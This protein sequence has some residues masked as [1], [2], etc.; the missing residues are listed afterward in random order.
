MAVKDPSQVRQAIADFELFLGGKRAP[1]LIGHSLAT[2]LRMEIPQLANIIINWSSQVKDQYLIDVILGARNKVFDIFFYRV[3]KFEAIYSFFPVFEQNLIEFCPSDVQAHLAAIFQ[4]FPWQ[5]IRPIGTFREQ[6]KFVIE[7][8]PETKVQSEAF[9]DTIYKNAT[10]AVMSIDKKFTFNDEQTGEKIAGFQNKVQGIFRDFVDQVKDK[11]QKKEIVLANES[12][13]Y[14]DYQKK[15]SFKIEQYLTQ[16]LDLGIALFNDDFL[17]QSVQIFGIIQELRLEYKLNLDDVKKFQDKAEFFS[18]QK[19]ED[20]A[21]SRP[22]CLLIKQILSLFLYWQ[23]SRLIIQLQ[24]EE[25][26]R[27]RRLILKVLECYGSDVY[28][29]LITELETKA[30]KLPWWYA[31][32]MAYILGRIYTDNETQKNQAVELLVSYWQP[33]AQRQLVQQI[34]STLGHIGTDT[35]C[36]RLIEKMK[37]LEP[38]I[39]KDKSAADYFTRSISALI[40]VESDRAL[41]NAIDSALK[42]EQLAQHIDK[43]GRIYLSER[44]VNLYISKIRK[45]VSRLKYSFSLLGDRETALELLRVIGPMATDPVKNL[46]QE[47]IKALPRKHA[48]ALEAESIMRQPALPSYARDHAL[49][50][51]AMVKNVSE[52]TCHIL[53][54]HLTGKLVVRN[55]DQAV[56]EIDFDQ[57]TAVRASVSA[58]HLEKEN[59]FYW[60]F[61][62]DPRDIESIYFYSGPTYGQ[63]D[64]SRPTDA[65]ICEGLVQRGQVLQISNN[66]ISPESRLRQKRVNSYFTNFAQT[67]SPE[68]YQLVWQCLVEDIDIG[69]LQQMTKL[70]KSELLKILFHFLKQDMVVV[71]GDNQKTTELD[72]EEGLSMLLLNI[73]RIERRPVMFNYYKT[74]AEVC[75]DIMRIVDEEVCRFSFGVLRNYFLE[76]YQYRRAFTSTNIEICRQLLEWVSGYAQ[77]RDNDTRQSLLDFINFTFKIEDASLQSAAAAEPVAESTSVLEKLENIDLANDPLDD[78]AGGV[79]ESMFDELF[80]SLDSVLGSGLGLGL[81]DNEEAATER[82]A[83]MLTEAEEQ[84]IRDLFDNIALAYVKPLKDFIRELYRNWEA[85]RPTLLEWCEIIEPIFTLLSGSSSKMGYQQIADAVKDLESIVVNDKEAAQTEGRDYFS[86]EAAHQMVTYYQRLCELQPKTFSLVISDEDLND[87]KEILVVKFILKQIPDVTE[88][89]LNKLLFAGLNS[90]DKYMQSKPDEIAALTGMSRELAD[91]IYMKFYQ[92]R[93]IYYQD[94]EDYFQKYLAMFELQLN[95]LKGMHSEVEYL[96]IEEQI[97]KEDAHTRK[98]AI[99]LER[100]RMLW[101]LFILLCIRQEY[102]LVETIQQSVFEVRIQLLDEYLS[103]LASSMQDAYAGSE[104]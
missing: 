51:L 56:C 46:C 8:R 9:N 44:I 34:I 35:A 40:T 53:E 81:E 99:I 86:Q 36:T 26:R 69:G 14:N 94:T 58:Y 92:Y 102:D 71:D 5:D 6:N 47:I 4:Q 38:Q 65:L 54:T 61:L 64:I 73:S 74:S 20:Y 32:N 103:R 85:E 89:L 23:P 62:L 70:T 22:S 91:D 96:T 3:V 90:F 21:V 43:F 2:I 72:I 7:K 15:E 50:K 48:L 42:S 45:E 28:G 16:L 17:Y 98:E 76:Y 18:I 49:Q 31:R 27:T 13:R 19:I 30:A 39:D 57:G 104:S 29:L 80:G 82:Q 41:E 88:K 59:A 60:A 12:D 10:F 63:A 95:L 100:Q 1:A 68:K 97:G 37:Y 24:V 66:Y 75:A 79:D 84:M 25:S 52:M 33:K 55:I 67:E 87:K 93:N 78:V 83:G 11:H 77:T 101:S